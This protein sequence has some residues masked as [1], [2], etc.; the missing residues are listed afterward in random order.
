MLPASL[1]GS[2]FWG[3]DVMIPLGFRADP[4]LSEA[5]LRR[6]VGAGPDDLVVLDA[7]G[8]ERIPRG[9]FRPLSRAGIRLASAGIASG[10][11]AGRAPAMNHRRAALYLQIPDAYCRS[12]GGLRS[13]QCG[14]AV[15]FLG[16][17]GR[18]P[19]VR[20]RGRDRPVPRGAADSGAIV[21]RLRLR[22]AHPL[23][24]RAGRA[25]PGAWCDP[26][27]APDQRTVPGLAEST[28]QCGG[29]VRLALPRDSG[30]RRSARAAPVSR[31]S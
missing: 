3:V 15:E 12:F 19:D 16:R 20:L 29:A 10:R 30:R 5:A 17:A 27:P 25:C 7:N 18:G 31:T 26:S 28:P 4:E 2:R 22:A 13:A 8:Y 21:P 23:P 6:L 1:G 24:D 11:H 14:E 9:S